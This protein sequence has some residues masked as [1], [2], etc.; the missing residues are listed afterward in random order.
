MKSFTLAAV[1]L[2]TAAV[3]PLLAADIPAVS[4]VDAVTV[5]PSGAE[6]TRVAEAKISAGEH[7]L[8]FEGLP[9]DLMPETIRVEGD[10]LGKVEIGSV[11]ARM[12]YV[13]STDIDAKR[14]VL[15]A[16]IQSLQDERGVLDQTISD[17]EYQKSLMQQLASGA[18]AAWKPLVAARRV[19]YDREKQRRQ[20]PRR[21]PLQSPCRAR[22]RP[23]HRCQ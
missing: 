4:K 5:F 22:Q 15:E 19:P 23:Q 8:I 6:V 17:A 10:A 13:G 2:A 20:V 18:R 21:R 11:D 1:L 9:G 14:K 7:S 12:V 3:T 16:Q